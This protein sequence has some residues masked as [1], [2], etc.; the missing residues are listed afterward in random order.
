VKSRLN[1]T[2]PLKTLE[3]SYLSLTASF[4]TIAAHLG[5]IK[6]KHEKILSYDREQKQFEFRHIE[7]HLTTQVIREENIELVSNG[8]SLKTSVKHPVL[9]CRDDRLVYVRADEVCNDDALVHYQLPWSA[10]PDV[11]LNAWFA[12]AH[13]GDGAYDIHFTYKPGRVSWAQRAKVHGKRYIFKIRAAEREVVERYAEFFSIFCGSQA[14]VVAAQTPNGTPVWDYTVASFAASKAARLFDN[15][16]GKAS[17]SNPKTQILI[18][19]DQQV[20]HGRVVEVMDLARSAGLHR[21]AIVTQ[22]KS[23]REQ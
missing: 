21:L 1:P 7:Q 11:A 6:E 20:T 9:V 19:A 8:T 23:N 15:Q 10:D 18:Q 5:E 12:G 2:I 3:E 13:L 16:F 4:R 17:Q 14:Q 22:P